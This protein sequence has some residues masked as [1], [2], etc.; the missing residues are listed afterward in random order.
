MVF[1]RV[2]LGIFGNKLERKKNRFFKNW[3]KKIRVKWPQRT[4]SNFLVGWQQNFFFL[5]KDSFFSLLL[6]MI[7]M[8]SCKTFLTRNLRFRRSKLE[9]FYSGKKVSAWS[10]IFGPPQLRC[11][12]EVGIWV[13]S[14]FLPESNALAYCAQKRLMYW[15]KSFTEFVPECRKKWLFLL[16]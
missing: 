12:T 11:S 7:R 8:P 13:R 6:S 3:R 14:K 9:C 15:D 1:R 2:A 16:L 5:V 10:D 4:G